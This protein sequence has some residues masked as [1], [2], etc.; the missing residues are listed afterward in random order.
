[1]VIIDYGS[2]IE[3]LHFISRIAHFTLFYIC[4]SAMEDNRNLHCTV[5]KF[6]QYF[7]LLANIILDKIHTDEKNQL[8]LIVSYANL[9]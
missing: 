1:M 5:R 7:R 3:A 2:K 4:I 9:Q 8:C 6:H